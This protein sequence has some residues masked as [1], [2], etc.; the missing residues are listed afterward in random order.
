MS[1]HN[2]KGSIWHRWEPHIHIPGTI[3]NNQYKTSIDSLD[4]FCD[5]IENAQ[6][7]IK[8]LGITDYYS[9]ASYEQ[10]IALK[11]AGRLKDV[12]LIFPNIELR[13]MIATGS[14]KGINAHLLF[15]PEDPNHIAWV[16]MP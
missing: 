1:V 14:E 6:P 7:T 13:F 8:A 15:S 12:D 5:A 3:L 2:S 9:I 10:I 16:L 4:K 11:Q